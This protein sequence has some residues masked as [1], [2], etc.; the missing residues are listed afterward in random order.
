MKI[1]ES[2]ASFVRNCYYTFNF[3]GRHLHFLSLLVL[4]LVICA[5][6]RNLLISFNFLNRRKLFRKINCGELHKEH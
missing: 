2:G 3:T 4:F 5:F 6:S 1:F